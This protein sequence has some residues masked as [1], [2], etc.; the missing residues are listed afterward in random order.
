MIL[1]DKEMLRGSLEL[2][3]LSRID[4]QDSYGGQL[5]KDILEESN[6][7]LMVSEGT[8]YSLLKRLEKKGF[9][10]SY[11]G[12]EQ[13]SARRKYYRMT[14]EGRSI[15]QRKLVDWRVLNQLI[16]GGDE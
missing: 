10:Q 5:L 16:E 9:V 7:S 2:I 15:Y 1:L 12:E 6:E 13:L 14:D 4:R 11:W 8:L 3:V